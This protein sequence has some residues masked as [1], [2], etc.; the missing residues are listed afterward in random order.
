MV[1]SEGDSLAQS[2]LS[3]RDDGG[4]NAGMRESAT[5]RESGAEINGQQLRRHENGD[6]GLQHAR[7]DQL[8]RRVLHSSAREGK[9][10]EGWYLGGVFEAGDERREVLAGQGGSGQ[11]LEQPGQ[12]ERDQTI[13]A[14]IESER[15]RSEKERERR[16]GQM[17]QQQR[18]LSR[19]F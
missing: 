1:G 12:R 13:V 15:E 7:L 18:S 4:G 5:Q 14:G 3:D 10:N 16:R 8:G 2:G 6:D 19:F 9:K 17:R 11:Q